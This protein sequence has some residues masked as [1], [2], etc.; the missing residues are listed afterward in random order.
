MTWPKTENF[1]SGFSRFRSGSTKP[2]T[3][4][5]QLKAQLVSFRYQVANKPLKFSL[6][7]LT[8]TQKLALFSSPFIIF[9]TIDKNDQK[10]VIF[11]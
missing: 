8:L 7:P 10:I 9:T 6:F 5:S 11:F 1:Q 3:N 4:N 2:S